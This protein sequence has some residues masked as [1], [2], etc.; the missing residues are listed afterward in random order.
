MGFPSTVFRW[1]SFIPL[2][3]YILQ[4]VLSPVLTPFILYFS[5]RPR[6]L[7]IVDF[8]RSFTVQVVGVG[9]VCSFALM[10]I[11]K[12]GNP[13]WQLKDVDNL[14]LGGEV[15]KRYLPK[16]MEQAEHGK[17]ELSLIHFTLTNP[18]WKMPV[19]AKHFIEEIREHALEDLKHSKLKTKDVGTN[20]AMTQSLMSFG[21]LGGQVRI[22]Y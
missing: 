15:Q 16:Q 2:Q 4:E 13:D 18:E 12:H 22:Y 19:E 3:T 9:N 14:Q 21:S 10:D 5:F 11:K 17:T 8:F 20:T 6:S 7:E 1:F